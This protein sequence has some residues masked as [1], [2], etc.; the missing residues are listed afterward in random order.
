MFLGFLIYFLYGIKNSGE[1]APLEE[2][3]PL[4]AT[5]HSGY[6]AAGE[7]EVKEADDKT[8]ETSLDEDVEKK[9]TPQ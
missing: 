6:S 9:I 8:D 7:T 1:N 4:K 2:E 5:P 3:Q